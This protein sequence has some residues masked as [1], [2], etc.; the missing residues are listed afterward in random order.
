[1]RLLDDSS[2]KQLVGLL[3]SKADWFV[4]FND[5]MYPDNEPTN[6]GFIFRN[7]NDE[8]VL[9]FVHSDV[10]VGTFNGEHLG[11]TLNDLGGPQSEKLAKEFEEWKSRYA[12]PE[13]ATPEKSPAQ[14]PPM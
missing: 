7:G 13:I 6:V 1:M 14:P 5:L 2:R 3:G 4:G 8:L 10:V 9:F 12:Q 11:G